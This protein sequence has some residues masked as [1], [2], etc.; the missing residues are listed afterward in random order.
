MQFCTNDTELLFQKLRCSAKVLA[1]G[2]SSR[3][4]RIWTRFVYVYDSN[5][6][7]ATTRFI[8]IKMWLFLLNIALDV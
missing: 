1:Y 4:L 2:V 7:S 8:M 5:A 6:I 3:K